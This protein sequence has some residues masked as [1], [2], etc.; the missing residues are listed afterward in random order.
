MTKEDADGFVLDCLRRFSDSDRFTL[1][2]EMKNGHAL[3]NCLAD[4]VNELMESAAEVLSEQE[5]ELL[6]TQARNEKGTPVLRLDDMIYALECVHDGFTASEEDFL[7]ELWDKG[8]TD[9][10]TLSAKEAF[11]LTTIY[12]KYVDDDPNSPRLVRAKDSKR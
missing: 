2:I 8:T 1:M 5:L 7:Q 11:R 9:G 6:V 4:H 10:P 3:A 12:K